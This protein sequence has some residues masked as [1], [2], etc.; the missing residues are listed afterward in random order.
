MCEHQQQDPTYIG[1][2]DI[3]TEIASQKLL[4]LL[5]VGLAKEH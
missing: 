5:S 4:S 2:D 3:P 1:L